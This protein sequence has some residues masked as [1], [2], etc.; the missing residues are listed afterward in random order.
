LI[1][2]L[3]LPGIP[4]DLT[5][6]QIMEKVTAHHNPKPSVIIKCFEF[7]TRVQKEGE[8]VAEFVAALRKI[9][10]YCKFGTFLDDLL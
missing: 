3:A 1:K 7:K 5:F 2:T 8:S 4:K 9:T 6:E 10:E